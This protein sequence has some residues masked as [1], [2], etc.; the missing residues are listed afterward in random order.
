MSQYD[1]AAE[2]DLHSFHIAWVPV[3]TRS[4]AEGTGSS[5]QLSGADG[6]KHQTAVMRMGAL[7]TS[8]LVLA[9]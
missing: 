7:G 1:S 3:T 9:G 5:T 6:G 2:G 8:L 4:I